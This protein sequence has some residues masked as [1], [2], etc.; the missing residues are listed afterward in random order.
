MTKQSLNDR[1][2]SYVISC[3]GQTPSVNKFD[4][5]AGAKEERI[6]VVEQAVE[7]LCKN[8]TDTTYLGL[9]TLNSFDKAQFINRFKQAM[10][11]E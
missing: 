4:Y 6:L 3:K 11:N 10:K 2:E 1:A 7:W 5:I 8:M 9:D